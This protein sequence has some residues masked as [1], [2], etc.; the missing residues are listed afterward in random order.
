MFHREKSVLLSSEQWEHWQAWFHRM[1]IEL[2][3]IRTL[4]LE[5]KNEVYALA[6]ANTKKY[7][8]KKVMAG[9]KAA[10][11]RRRKAAVKEMVLNGLDSET[12][13]PSGEG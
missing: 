13:G 12:V 6:Q 10:E 8:P 2:R 5:T 9:I 3:E 11:T 4:M 7:N 1:E